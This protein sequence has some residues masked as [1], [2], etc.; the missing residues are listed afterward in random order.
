MQLSLVT[1]DRQLDHYLFNNHHGVYN[2][3]KIHKITFS[4]SH[5]MM[6]H[7]NY[8]YIVRI[9]QT[10]KKSEIIDYGTQILTS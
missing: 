7:C 10:H 6:T 8:G 1:S 3:R 5:N 9:G 4:F 2:F